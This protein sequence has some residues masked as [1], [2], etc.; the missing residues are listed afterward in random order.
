MLSVM[1]QPQFCSFTMYSRMLMR[2]TVGGWE[3]TGLMCVIFEPTML[4]I[5][6][7]LLRELWKKPF[8]KN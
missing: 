5:C 8:P 7:I 4:V 3:A 2:L 6:W 1:I